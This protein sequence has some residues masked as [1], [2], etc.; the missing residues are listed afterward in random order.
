M[1]SLIELIEQSPGVFAWLAAT[2]I[3][4]RGQR[5]YSNARGR[6]VLLAFSLVLTG[7]VLG[8]V[9]LVLLQ[10]RLL[11]LGAFRY[12]VILSILSLPQ[13][14]GTILIIY[15]LWAIGKLRT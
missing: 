14:V 2:G 1:G 4:Y 7:S 6:T 8:S 9:S 15:G 5:R 11:D 12:G 10:T 13:L 3:V